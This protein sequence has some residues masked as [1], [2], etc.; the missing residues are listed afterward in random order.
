MTTVAP[1]RVRVAASQYFVRPIRAIDEF[2]DQVSSVVATSA[3]YNSQLLV[4]PEYFT[5][6]LASLDDPHKPVSEIV[7]GVANHV[8]RFLDFMSGLAE[9]Y[10]M[11]IVGGTIP[12]VDD[13]GRV[14][15]DCYVFSPSGGRHSQGKLHM[16]RFERDDWNVLERDR[17]TVFDTE[18]GRMA[19]AVCYD[20]EFPELVRSLARYGIDILAVPSSTDDRHGFL[21]VRYCAHARAIENQVYVIH[22]PT[23]GGLP[24]VPDLSLNYGTAAVLT[25]CDYPFARDGIETE[26]VLNQDMVAIAE[27]DLRAI[28][29]SRTFGTVLPLSDARHTQELTH[30]IDIVKL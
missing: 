10:R 26:G 9:R 13:D 22:S 5:L 28:D 25:P 11:Y 20:V 7:R 24:W 12:A 1:D 15:N 17:L 18:F 6:Q 2:F 21:R 4:L 19:V 30:N 27:L 14:R 29:S 23:V 16:T 8:P 3:G